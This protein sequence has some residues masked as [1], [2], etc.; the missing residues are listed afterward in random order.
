MSNTTENQD[1]RAIVD[2][3]MNAA[4]TADNRRGPNGHEEGAAPVPE[5]APTSD[6]HG[7]TGNETPDAANVGENSEEVNRDLEELRQGM[8][9][10]SG[11]EPIPEDPEEEP[12]PPDGIDADLIRHIPAKDHWLILDGCD[13]EQVRSEDGTLWWAPTGGTWRLCSNQR[14]P[15]IRL[16][17]RFFSLGLDQQAIADV[18]RER[19]ADDGPLSDTQKKAIVKQALKSFQD[20][21]LGRAADLGSIDWWGQLAGYPAGDVEIGSAKCLITYES[22]PP[23]GTP[24]PRE[25]PEGS[26]HPAPVTMRLLR[27]VF[28]SNGQLYTFLAWLAESRRRYG[29]YMA[30]GNYSPL[31]M[32]CVA[33]GRGT[34]KTVLA[35]RIVAPALGS[36]APTDPM[37][38]WTGKVGFNSELA[39]DPLLLIDDS[40]SPDSWKDRK[41]MAHGF[42]NWMFANQVKITTKYKNAFVARPMNAVM[43][44]C[45]DDEN[46]L[47]VIPPLDK[48]M[49]DK[50]ILLKAESM[51]EGDPIIPGYDNGAE[52]RAEL[53]AILEA[54]MPEFLGYIDN[55]LANDEF[56]AN[57]VND[58]ETGMRHRCGVASY[59]NPELVA[60]LDQMDPRHYFG[61]MF[62]EAVDDGPNDGVSPHWLGLARGEAKRF[63]SM[64]IFDAITT[65]YPKH[66][67]AMAGQHS[68]S[69]GRDIVVWLRGL[70]NDEALPGNDPANWPEFPEGDIR[71]VVLYGGTTHGSHTIWVRRQQAASLHEGRNKHGP[72]LETGRGFFACRRE[73]NRTPAAEMSVKSAIRPPKC[74]L[75]ASCGG[76]PVGW[77]G[78]P[79]EQSHRLNP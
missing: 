48:D 37:N 11:E 44:L 6:E 69:R 10:L 51:L 55:A 64:E 18:E 62:V 21:E 19:S 43:L 70:V 77:G 39:E 17:K 3:L 40:V 60:E 42:K 22:T 63:R 15:K 68:R 26:P 32:L 1:G 2:D 76:A 9:W 45:N 54:E 75:P 30:T 33:G 28:G 16:A 52:K 12:T 74:R 57:I 58:P 59:F 46:S 65:K 41:D 14:L 72:A 50:I 53:D 73:E 66:H 27:K 23:E 49:K 4:R 56:P 67:E 31:Q 36:T 78:A 25:R 35:N 7:A 29:D 79:F 38:V 47:R 20:R 8:R 71:N 34:G 13:F 5:A 61:T 24:P